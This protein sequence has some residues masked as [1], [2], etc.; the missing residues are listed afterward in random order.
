MKI[1]TPKH[2]FISV[3]PVLN[4]HMKKRLVLLSLLAGA[5]AYA[6]APGNGQFNDRQP[7]FPERPITGV[8]AAA[9]TNL[10]RT[11]IFGTNRTALLTNGVR[12]FSGLT[13][14]VPPGANIPGEIPTLPG[15]PPTQPGVPPQVPINPPPF[16]G[17]PGLPGNTPALPG[18]TPG[19]PGTT[20]GLPGNQPGLDQNPAG[21]PP[22]GSFTTPGAIPATPANP[23]QTPALPAPPPVPRTPV[24]LRR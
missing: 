8:E 17:E 13:N 24:P 21:A 5:G 1:V 4:D 18:T 19:L 16:Q 15:T 7:L 22:P 12:G 20:P 2:K 9:P 3:R 10:G 14:T 11:N 6:Q 23:A